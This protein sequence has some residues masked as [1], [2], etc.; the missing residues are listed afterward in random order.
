MKIN[1]LQNYLHM[2]IFTIETGK[3][4]LDGG[5]IFGVVPKTLWSKNY[6]AD[7]QNRCL[8]SMRCLLVDDGKHKVLF[9][10][11]IGDKQDEKFFSFFPVIKDNDLI[12]SLQKV[13]YKAEDI[14]D[15]VLSHLHF[16]HCGGSVYRNERGELKTMFPNA[17]FHVSSSHWESAINP[18]YLE[19]ASFLTENIKP[20]ADAGQLNLITKDTDLFPWLHL[21]LFNGHTIGQIASLI[22]IQN[23]TLVYTAD[24]IPSTLHISMSWLTA[25]DIQPLVVLDEKEKFLKEAFE[26]KYFFYFE[27]DVFTTIC[28]LQQTPRGIRAGTSHNLTDL[29]VN[30]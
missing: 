21:R 6:P 12:L 10:T 7:E 9:D 27:H 18:N 22:Q 11:G 16:D 19:R 5:P 3:L 15:V 20:I 23:K 13:G 28:D 26:N 4:L 1:L 14:T 24:V 29:F 8:L 2:K 25:Y 17:V 30:Q